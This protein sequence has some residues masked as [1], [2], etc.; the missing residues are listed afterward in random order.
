MAR[1][2]PTAH[3]AATSNATA[4]QPRRVSAIARSRAGQGDAEHRPGKE[5]VRSAQQADEWQVV[6]QRDQAAARAAGE[7]QPDAGDGEQ[8]DAHPIRTPQGD[9]GERRRGEAEVAEVQ[10]MGCTIGA[11]KR[12]DAA[13]HGR[14]TS[15]VLE[16]QL[17]GSR[18][19]SPRRA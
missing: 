8:T 12:G 3:A 7:Q 18:G 17:S 15:P 16:A 11:E 19:C 14:F 1:K 4:C 10:G 9:Q 6:Q 5:L 13:E 2:K